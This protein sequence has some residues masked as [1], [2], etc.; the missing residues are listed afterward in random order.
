MVST[1]VA[2]MPTARNVLTR[3]DQLSSASRKEIDGFFP[4]WGLFCR[5]GQNGP[6]GSGRGPE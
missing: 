4:L 1:A 5:G 2:T 6:L 3:S